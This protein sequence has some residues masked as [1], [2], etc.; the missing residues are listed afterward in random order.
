MWV[1]SLLKPC[2]EEA[3]PLQIGPG[4]GRGRLLL[5]ELPCQFIQIDAQADERGVR[6][7][8]TDWREFSTRPAQHRCG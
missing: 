2:D 7:H 1:S 6:E 4:C 8:L 3:S 5:H